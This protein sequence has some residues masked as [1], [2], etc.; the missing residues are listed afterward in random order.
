M[1]G[2]RTHAAGVG[3]VAGM[4]GSP[5]QTEKPAGMGRFFLFLLYKFRI[6]YGEKKSAKYD[7]V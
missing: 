3:W 1:W 5:L 4:A 7:L 2:T 6:S